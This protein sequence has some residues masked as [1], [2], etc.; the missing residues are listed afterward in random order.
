M[1][2]TTFELKLPINYTNQ[3]IIDSLKKQG[4]SKFTNYKI[5]R[6]SLDARKKSNIFWNIKVEIDTPHI[7][8]EQ[9]AKS[10]LNLIKTDRDKHVV[11]VGSG[12]AGIF[13]G[14]VLLQAGFNVTL[15]EQGKKVSSRDGDIE[16]LLNKAIFNPTSNFA[17]GE[18]GAGTYSDGKLTSRSKHISKE[19]EF[20]LSTFINN[21]AP[22][23]IFSMVHPHIGSDNLKIVAKNM[24]NEFLSLGGNIE[25]NTTFITFKDSFGRVNNIETDKGVVDCDYLI[26]ATGHSSFRTYRELIRKGLIFKNK[27]FAIGFRAEHEQSLINNAQWGVDSIKGLKAAE[28]RLTSKTDSSSVFSFCMCPGGTVVPAAALDRT[29]VVNG[30][31]NYNRD[32]KFANA[33]VVSSFNFSQELKREVSPLESLDLLQD[34]E[35]GYYRATGGYSVPAMRI[36][37]FINGKATANIGETSYSLGLTPYNLVDLLPKGVVDPLRLGLKDFSR[38]LY[39]YETGNILGLESKTSSPIQVERSREG[40][41]SGFTNIYFVGEGSGWAGGIVSSGADGIKGALD[42]IKRES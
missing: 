39:G 15:I 11:I 5:L 2:K 21:G 34:L 32:G 28:Y 24:R 3:G 18:G 6:K 14:I 36:S 30:M 31:S 40:L 29:S 17:F 27:N 10:S 37:D 7:T 23:E 1:K 13:S 35:E 42:I 38:K 20:I 41:C 4:A 12:P 26:L 19:K 25:F 22:E 8:F 33:A 16:D 9:R